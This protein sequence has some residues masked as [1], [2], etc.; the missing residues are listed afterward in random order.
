MPYGGTGC[1]PLTSKAST[2]PVKRKIRPSSKKYR[3]FFMI[4]MRITKKVFLVNLAYHI[5]RVFSKRSSTNS[6][7]PFSRDSY[8]KR[9]SLASP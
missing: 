8:R 1:N 3:L 4:E 5:L 7:I 6:L 9:K 2:E